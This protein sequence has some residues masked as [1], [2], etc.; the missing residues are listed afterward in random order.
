MLLLLIGSS[1][2]PEPPGG[3]HHDHQR[4][5]YDQNDVSNESEDDAEDDLVDEA[6]EVVVSPPSLLFRYFNIS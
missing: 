5:Q 4:H 2:W 3:R 1:R 6:H